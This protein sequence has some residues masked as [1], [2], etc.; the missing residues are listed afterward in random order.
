MKKNYFLFI[1]LFFFK[2]LCFGEDF[3]LTTPRM[4]GKKVEEI[5]RYLYKC[6]L[7]PEEEIDGWYGPITEKSIRTLQNI[8]DYDENG[9]VDS[10]LY[11]LLKISDFQK[12]VALE[13][14]SKK[15]QKIETFDKVFDFSGYEISLYRNESKEIS[16]YS[17]AYWRAFEP[18]YNREVQ[19]IE[20][21]YFVGNSIHKKFIENPYEDYKEIKWYFNIDTDVRSEINNLY[22]RKF[23]WIVNKNN[24]KNEYEISL[25][26]FTNDKYYVNR[27]LT[28]DKEL[29][30]TSNDCVRSK[31]NSIS[32]ISENN[33][34]FAQ[35]YII[36]RENNYL[37]IYFYYIGNSEES[38]LQKI[39]SIPIN[40][41]DIVEIVEKA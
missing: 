39:E 12:I 28:T 10:N 36:F 41:N 40:E 7:L 37:N 21:Y 11:N 15:N 31:R 8:I 4:N 14:Q 17:K 30:I 5:Q 22:K 18:K 9:I 20:V 35:G 23:K 25:Y 38:I 1:I 3:R 13:N 24:E 19:F 2:I 6:N 29:E 32:T 33:T 26:D 27:K 16:K 34:D